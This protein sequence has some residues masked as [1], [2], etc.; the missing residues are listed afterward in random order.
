MD[1]VNHRMK[2]IEITL[3]IA[4]VD[5]AAGMQVLGENIG[6]FVNSPVLN[7]GFL[8]FADNP[9]LVKPAIEKIDLKMKGPT[10]HVLIKI[11]KVRIRVNGFI[12][13]SPT[14]MLCQLLGQCRFSRADITRD[15][16][17]FNGL[18]KVNCLAKVD[19][20]YQKKMDLVIPQP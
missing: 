12:K 8:A 17:V 14:V 15:G 3:V 13:G 11:A 19:I 9:H 16:D 6:V 1:K 5:M 10:G 4:V 2:N 7:D 18:Q 20:F